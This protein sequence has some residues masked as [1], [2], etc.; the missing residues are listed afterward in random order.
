V[1]KVGDILN[2]NSRKTT[3]KVN[4]STELDEVATED[5][6]EHFARIAN[7][8]HLRHRFENFKVVKGTENAY[9]A[10]RELAEAKT[11]KPFLLCYGRPGNG[12]THLLAAMIY[13]MAKELNTFARYRRMADLLDWLKKGM[14]REPGSLSVEDRVKLAQDWNALVLDDY[15]IEYGTDWETSKLEQI[16]DE[17]YRR[18]KVTVIVTNKD[19]TELPPRIESRFSD[20]EVARLV[21]NQGEDYRK[22]KRGKK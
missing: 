15:G 1:E 11:D 2:D 13:T 12:K 8:P 5:E 19:R 20:P 14:D 10:F 7:L 9:R 6:L 16:I 21:C 17:R 18:G 3:A 4:H 22:L